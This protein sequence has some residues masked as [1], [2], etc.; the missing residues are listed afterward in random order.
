M[1]REKVVIAIGKTAVDIAV[2]F[3]SVPGLQPAVDLLFKIVELCENVSINRCLIEIQVKM[4]KWAELGFIKSFFKQDDIKGDIESCLVTVSDCFMKFQ[5]AGTIE[6]NRWQEDFEK[7]YS[8]DQKVILAHLSD[9]KNGP[10]MALEVSNE[11][12]NKR[13]RFMESMQN[14]LGQH[15][16]R[17]DIVHSG[18]SSNLYQIQLEC[19]EI[20]PDLHLKRGEVERIGT[21]PLKGEGAMDIYEGLYLK[22]EKVAIKTVRASNFS[23]KSVKR[24]SRE[25]KV[26]TE[27]WKVDRGRHI[28]PFYGFCLEDGPYPR[29]AQAYGRYMVSPWKSN[30]TAI[31]YV[32]KFD[33]AVSYPELIINIAR[34]IQVLHHMKPLIVH[35]D[36]KADN[37]VI[38][39]MGNPLIADFGLSQIIEE[40]TG[41]PFS[42]SRMTNSW[43]WSAPE[44]IIDGAPP[45]LAVDIYAFAMTVLEIYTHKQPFSNIKAPGKVLVELSNGTC[46]PRPLEAQVLQRGLDDNTWGLMIKCWNSDAS[47]RPNIDAILSTLGASEAM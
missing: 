42:Q 25:V 6:I 15:N 38:D 1:G 40:I 21:F 28:L 35:G 37:I 19:K 9:I 30:G 13:V 11:P 4:A 34:G 26:W 12:E 47:S 31:E 5:F 45:S 29:S 18:L 36:L 43:R 39:E 32:T 17:G 3:A 14:E 8:E 10:A 24:F 27:L 20:L 33:S 41:V 2:E 46:P 22:R 7:I 23:P 44:V 16:T